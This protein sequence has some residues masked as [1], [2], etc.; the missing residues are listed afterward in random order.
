MKKILTILFIIVAPFIFESC[1]ND[2]EDLDIKIIS[3]NNNEENRSEPSGDDDDGYLFL[4][5]ECAQYTCD[6]N[7][8]LNSDIKMNIIQASIALSDIK[9]NSK[10][11]PITCV[12]LFA[13]K[14]EVILKEIDGGTTLKQG[15]LKIDNNN[16]DL[17]DKKILP[18]QDFTSD[19][20]VWL[21]NSG[22]PRN[23]GDPKMLEDFLV[24]ANGEYS[25]SDSRYK[26]VILC[27]ADHGTGAYKESDLYKSDRILCKTDYDKTSWITSADIKQAL[28][29]SGFS[30]LNGRK[31]CIIWE[32][33]CLQMGVEVLY[34]L[35]GAADYLLGS[36]NE[37]YSHDYEALLKC[38]KKGLLITDIGRA[39]VDEYI[40]TQKLSGE[41]PGN[42]NTYS[43]S[44]Y[45]TQT[46][47]SLD[48]TLLEDLKNKVSE[49]ARLLLSDSDHA[50][51]FKNM[52]D[53]DG[54]DKGDYSAAKGLC[55]RGSFSALRDL[56]FFTKSVKNVPGISDSL[57]AGC[58]DLTKC[59]NK[60][61]IKSAACSLGDVTYDAV[62]L[63]SDNNNAL[64]VTIVSKFNKANSA[65]NKNY[66][67]GVG[68]FGSN[69]YWGDLLETYFVNK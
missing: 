7:S 62:D 39:I 66:K 15:N 47:A 22:K 30:D 52:L 33:C 14:S 53:C 60:I 50:G 43:G 54:V 20:S 45:Y 3:V 63:T 31:P 41:L 18:G 36:E 26:N 59:I 16:L 13:N 32:D 46:F 65:Y 67:L 27:L 35:R 12:T 29:K 69:N 11:P 28:Q 25:A 24:W 68:S 57:V 5:Y 1:N 64:G 17:S 56:G 2:D 44:P 61:V 55:F 6:T 9:N 42:I 10:Y 49:F 21:K 58:D 37:S 34:E 8:T 38:F 51:T 48:A 4:L 23:M 40:T 19:Q